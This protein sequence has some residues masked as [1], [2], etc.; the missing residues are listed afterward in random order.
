MRYVI[1]LLAATLLLGGAVVANAAALPSVD[2]TKTIDTATEMEM[3]G[4][5]EVCNVTGD[6][7]DDVTVEMVD[8]NVFAKTT[9]GKPGFVNIGAT[10][11]FSPAL[12]PGTMIAA[13]TCE[14]FD[15]TASYSD[16]GDVRELRNEIAITL[17]GRQ[18]KI[19]RDIVS[20]ELSD[21][22]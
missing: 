3:T 15:F 5:V 21:P 2:V 17:E 4:T 20:Q 18:G 13:N 10:V 9:K 1:T 19:F 16:P 12:E 6:D 11:T 7:P 14:E 8:D 22:D